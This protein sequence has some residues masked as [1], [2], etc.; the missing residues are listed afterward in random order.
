MKDM[1][2]YELTSDDKK[3][4]TNML[5]NFQLKTLN[6][7]MKNKVSA[8]RYENEILFDPF[9]YYG[10]FG[11]PGYPV[12]SFQATQKYKGWLNT[13]GRIFMKP[14]IRKIPKP[15]TDCEKL[16]DKDV[17]EIKQLVKDIGDLNNLIHKEQKNFILYDESDFIKETVFTELNKNIPSYGIISLH[18]DYNKKTLINWKNKLGFKID[19]NIKRVYNIVIRRS[20][21][22]KKN[23]NRRLKNDEHFYFIS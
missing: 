19:K 14:Y 17:L 12:L 7:W 11:Q 9:T 21:S 8:Q 6:K 5:P 20:L 1:G 15:L 16:F 4:L 23:R 13:D 3:E 10:S 22:T 18:Y 2:T